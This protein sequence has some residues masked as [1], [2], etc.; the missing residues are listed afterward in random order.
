M[1]RRAIPQSANS[2][3][4]LSFVGNHDPFGIE[5]NKSLEGPLLSLLAVETFKEVHLFY[6]NDE[7]LRRASDV[8]R[9]L[10]AKGDQTR[11]RYVPIPAPDPTDHAALYEAMEDRSLH[12]V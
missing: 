5:A 8:V 9:A 1:R 2:R 11:V 6:N 12:I 10:L 4:L 7:Y 3:I